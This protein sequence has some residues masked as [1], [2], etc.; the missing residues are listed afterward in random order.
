MQPGG[1]VKATN[2][3]AAA[4]EAEKKLLEVAVSELKGNITKGVEF[5][6]SSSAKL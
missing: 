5:A 6:Q 2:P 4:S 3:L 1:V